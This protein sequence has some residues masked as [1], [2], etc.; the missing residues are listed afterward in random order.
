MI[1]NYKNVLHNLVF[2]KAFKTWISHQLKISHLNKIETL[3]LI[4]MMLK[5]HVD[6]DQLESLIGLSIDNVQAYFAHNQDDAYLLD[7]ILHECSKRDGLL[8]FFEFKLQQK[9][10]L[11]FL[12]Q[13]LGYP[14]FLLLM[15]LL[16]LSVLYVFVVPTTY[17]QLGLVS[18]LTMIGIQLY[19]GLQ[20]GLYT[21][22]LIYVVLILPTKKIE[23]YHKFYRRF[24][25]NIWVKWESLKFMIHLRNSSY[26]GLPLAHF[27]EVFNTPSKNI[28]THLIQT[29]YSSLKKGE[30]KTQAF[31]HLDT[32][33]IKL[34]TIEDHD[35]R[36]ITRLNQYEPLLFSQ[37]QY[38][39]NTLTTL[40]KSFVYMQSTILILSVYQM[41]LSPL[42]LLEKIL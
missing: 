24:S 36:L 15:S 7:A 9:K 23:I 29:M 1:K 25:N 12:F 18:P 4:T 16:M 40:F 8:W 35:N 13:K 10:L 31:K 37:I 39:I 11:H 26:H 19:I 42:K 3:E 32:Y 6:R 34:L 33:L 2:Y 30:S 38:Q 5:M 14:T 22:V 17:Q 27:A 21:L 28:H 20:W 41:T